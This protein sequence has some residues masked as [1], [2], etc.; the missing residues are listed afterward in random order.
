MKLWR[1]K[2]GASESQAQALIGSSV[3]G[4]AQAQLELAR[5]VEPIVRR[6]VGSLLGRSAAAERIEDL[7]QDVLLEIF[8]D[9]CRKLAQYE[10]RNGCSLAAW[11]NLVT[12][13]IAIDRLRSDARREAP[14]AG[15]GGSCELGIE[16]IAATHAGPEEALAA[17]ETL[18]RVKAVLRQLAHEDRV[19]AELHFGRGLKMEEIAPVLKTGANALYVRKSRLLKRIRRALEEDNRELGR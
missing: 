16:R 3:A 9:G 1:A 7:C 10:G 19:L 18:H 13:R 14:L 4:N 2:G 15:R 8:R 17:I 12:V 5:Q 11:I 6:A